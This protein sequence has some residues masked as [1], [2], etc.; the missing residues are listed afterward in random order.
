MKENFEIVQILLNI[1]HF[2]NIEKGLIQ[3]LIEKYLFTNLN[4]EEEII[5]QD[6]F[7]YISNHFQIEKETFD[8]IYK[9]IWKMFKNILENLSN[10][11]KFFHNLGEY[12]LY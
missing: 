5:M 2:Y 12:F 4:N 8:F 6:F 7:E 9:I 3:I 10:Y 1:H 11:M